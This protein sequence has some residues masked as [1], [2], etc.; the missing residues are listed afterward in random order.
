MYIELCRDVY[1]ELCRDVYIE[2]CRDVYLCS[3]YRNATT[4]PPVVVGSARSVAA[5]TV[6]SV[7]DG[8]YFFFCSGQFC[9]Y[10]SIV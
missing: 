8:V 10:I 2:L 9:F 6:R 7:L 4:M 1:I 5:S 3:I